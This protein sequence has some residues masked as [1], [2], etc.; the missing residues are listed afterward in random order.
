[1]REIDA[2][3]EKFTKYLFTKISPRFWMD[4][5]VLFSFIFNT[6]MKL[7]A[8][9]TSCQIRKIAGCPWAGNAGNVFPPPRVSHP[10]THNGTCVRHVPWC[11]AGMLTGGFLW[12]RWRGKRSR[13]SRRVRNLLMLLPLTRLTVCYTSFWLPK[14]EEYISQN[15]FN[16]WPMKCFH[17]GIAFTKIDRCPN[18]NQTAVPLRAS[19][20]DNKH[21]TP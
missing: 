1:M 3:P 8:E 20:N 17:A 11:N 13:H 7:Y 16:E 19:T 4:G 14:I 12:S 5:F 21:Q 10:D 9:W 15:F 18:L 6:Q 2:E